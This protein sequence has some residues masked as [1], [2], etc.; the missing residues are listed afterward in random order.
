MSPRSGLVKALALCFC[1]N[2][3]S[4]GH[5][6][7]HS[8]FIQRRFWA[9]ARN[10][11]NLSTG[12]TASRYSCLYFITLV[13]LP[14]GVRAI[15]LVWRSASYLLW[16]TVSLSVSLR[17][18]VIEI[19]QAFETSMGFEV[20]LLCCDG[21]FCFYLSVACMFCLFA[22][23]LHT[24]TWPCDEWVCCPPPPPS[25]PLVFFWL[26]S[27]FR[28]GIASSPCGPFEIRGTRRSAEL[29]CANKRPCCCC[30]RCCCWCCCC[31]CWCCCCWSICCCCCPQSD[32][33]YEQRKGNLY[34]K[35][36]NDLCGLWR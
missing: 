10:F 20:F 24:F 11:Y 1:S 33:S 26:K 9:N 28:A 35:R 17:F 23:Q 12:K 16:Q 29:I 7:T 6:H 19:K 13:T 36:F 30:C 2:A 31:C 14:C 18:S 22:S 3:P 32:G 34:L 25:R 5:S 21:Y 4:S 15:Y 27:V 8:A